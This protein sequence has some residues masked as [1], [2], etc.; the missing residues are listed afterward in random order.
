[1]DLD[2]L[3]QLDRLRQSG[4]LTEDE[5]QIQKA[6]IVGGSGPE[7][8]RRFGWLYVLAGVVGLLL[9]GFVATTMHDWTGS[10][11]PAADRASV[12]AGA[13]VKQT[14]EEPTAAEPRPS[15]ATDPLFAWAA[16]EKVLGVTPEYLRSR[17]GVPKFQERGAMTFD[18]EGCE[19]EYR[20]VNGKV[21]TYS[22]AVTN[23]C[24]PI[25]LGVR[26]TPRTK[27]SAMDGEGDL[28]AD[29]LYS[30]GNAADPTI[31]LFY[32]PVHFRGFIGYRI[33]GKYGDATQKALEDWEKAVRTA[34]N[35]PEFEYVDE[36]F[37]C[38]SNPP[39]GVA[40]T[41]RNITVSWISVGDVS[42]C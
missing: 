9:V 1:M 28:I 6:Q 36:V 26:M 32:R 37:S 3:E 34:N 42:G 18:V 35:I 23:R 27:F 38:V 41:A 39:P 16:S 30:C 21:A 2:K 7:P 19:V 10:K 13:A 4:A 11:P 31:D 25:V 22:A 29:C 15:I 8:V 12:E 5:F 20:V 33:N 24:Q 40:A 14:P 17:L